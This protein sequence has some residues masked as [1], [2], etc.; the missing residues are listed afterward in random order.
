MAD[1]YFE[2]EKSY[3]DN[4]E[5]TAESGSRLIDNTKKYIRVV[6]KWV[7]VHGMQYLL[8]VDENQ[9]TIFSRSAN[10]AE[11]CRRSTDELGHDVYE[12]LFLSEET[13]TRMKYIPGLLYEFA[14]SSGEYTHYLFAENYKGYWTVNSTSGSTLDY[15]NDE[16]IDFSTM[17]LKDE[18][19]Y[20]FVT[21]TNANGISQ[22]M[23]L[24]IISN[25][26]KTDLLV[27]GNN[28]F[29][30]F[31]TNENN[32]VKFR[33]IKNYEEKSVSLYDIVK[34]LPAMKKVQNIP[35]ISEEL[36]ENL[37]AGIYQNEDVSFFERIKNN[38]SSGGNPSSGSLSSRFI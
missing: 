22:P 23:N 25:D 3:A 37:Y 10:Y 7:N 38:P 17:I 19:C 12:M 32:T 28:Y 16:Y 6:D 1:V 36:L 31:N 35:Y 26:H 20:E 9:E 33:N 30:L 14:I 34:R 4:I 29:E 18:A 11:I 24:T 8:K 2:E 13:T 15:L 27:I 5:S 21:M